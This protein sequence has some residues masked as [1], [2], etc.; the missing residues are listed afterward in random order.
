MKPLALLIV[1]CASTFAG[2]SSNVDR[3]GR[4]TQ[5]FFVPSFETLWERAATE[6][7]DT[8]YPVDIEAS[9]RAT[10]T[11]VSRW[12]TTLVPFSGKGTREQATLTLHPVE[13]RDNYWTVEAN[14][15]REQ[16]MNIMDP[17]N[18]R[19]AEWKNGARV[20]EQ[21]AMLVHRIETWFLGYEV[22]PQ[23]RDRYGMGA[24][25]TVVPPTPPDPNAGAVYQAP[26]GK[27]GGGKCGGGK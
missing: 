9:N 24:G 22:S 15:I 7:R 10:K 18:P 26:G 21:E 1:A 12:D 14:V 13:G 19:A 6:M 20:P 3:A 11:L 8:G 27:C 25:R 16:N 23:F 4:S 17:A 5:G 2:C